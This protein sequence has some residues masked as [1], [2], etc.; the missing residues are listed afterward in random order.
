MYRPP[1]CP[2][3]PTLMC[4]LVLNLHDLKFAWRTLSHLYML[5]KSEHHATVLND[6]Y[7][8]PLCTKRG[9]QARWKELIGPVELDVLGALVLPK[10][11]GIS[12]RLASGVMY[13]FFCLGLLRDINRSFPLTFIVRGG[14][15]CLPR[16]CLPRGGVQLDP[17]RH[18]I[19]QLWPHGPLPSKSLGVEDGQL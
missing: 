1:P 11:I 17:P 2:P 12:W 6:P 9:F 13:I 16:G 18:S 3:P 5:C 10:A 19:G 4:E 14:G 15:G 8:R 7:A